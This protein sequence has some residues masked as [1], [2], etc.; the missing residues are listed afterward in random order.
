MTDKI[1]TKE[2]WMKGLEGLMDAYTLFVPVRDGDFHTFMPL[3]EGKKPDFSYQNTRLSPK[4]L[5]YPR[6]ERLFEYSLDPKDPD[7]HILKESKKEFSP[8]AIVGIR[9]CDAHAFQIVQR[10]FD[11]P[12]YRDPWWVQHSEST[13]LI[14]LGCNDPCATCFC[15]QVGGGPFDSEGLDALLVDLGERY[16]IKGLTD[17]G[18]AKLEGFINNLSP[19]E[20]DALEI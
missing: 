4:S 16:L 20:R 8:R 3:G 14:G 13:T 12:E 5:I 17:K 11:N 6:S 15:T 10:N 9:P 7:A 2:E 19:E 18:E 1:F